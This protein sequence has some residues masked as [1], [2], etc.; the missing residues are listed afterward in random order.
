MVKSRDIPNELKDASESYVCSMWENVLI[1]KGEAEFKKQAEAR[2]E[3]IKNAPHVQAQQLSLF[4][5]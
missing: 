4:G 2:K 3:I 1:T 5:E